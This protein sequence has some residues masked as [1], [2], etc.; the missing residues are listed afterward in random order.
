M[1]AMTQFALKCF[2]LLTF[3]L[4]AVLTAL[5]AVAGPVLPKGGDDASTHGMAELY[6]LGV[7]IAPMTEALKES[8]I[9]AESLEK[10]G[11]TALIES[12]LTVTKG[13]DEENQ[14]HLVLQLMTGSDEA[15]PDAVSYCAVLSLRQ[16]V[17]LKRVE[18]EMGATTYTTYRV[19][20]EAQENLYDSIVQSTRNMVAEFIWILN[21]SQ[22]EQPT[23]G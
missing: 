10:I 23:D 8:Q 7:S 9:S 4:G 15:F 17:E 6:D 22:G 1:I 5:I 3:F 14:P 13:E 18:H 20:R 12:G 11:A 2:V 21:R 19:A 16:Y